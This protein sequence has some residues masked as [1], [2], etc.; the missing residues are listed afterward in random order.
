MTNESIFNIE[1][2][3]ISALKS[4]P[5]N[6]RQHPDDQI[7]HLI[8]SI[9]Q[10]GLYKNIVISK[11]NVILAGHGIVKAM[12]KIK[13]TEIPVI[14]L[15]V[16]SDSSDALKILIGDNEISKLTEIDD[17][18][19]SNM[20]KELK[21]IDVNNLL[22]TGFDEMMIANLLMITRSENEIKDFDEAAEWIG[23]PNFIR[24]GKKIYIKVYFRNE[25]DKEAFFKLLEQPLTIKK[26]TWWP[27]KELEDLK[28]LKLE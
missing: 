21:E 20:L 15:N 5:R 1:K 28:S 14:R 18:N 13:L 25:E 7:K 6:Y 3:Q 2:I 23:L 10:Y 9:Q 16:M 8:N 26:Y 12:E 4:H 19:L 22:G 11:D 17:I 24:M 27:Y